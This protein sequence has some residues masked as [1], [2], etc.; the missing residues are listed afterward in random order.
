LTLWFDD[1]IV[2]GGRGGATKGLFLVSENHAMLNAEAERFERRLTEEISGLRVEL[3]EQIA[4]VRAEMYR[5]LQ[6]L[7]LEL[8]DG[9]AAV[10]HEMGIMRAD[11]LKWSFLF[12]VG[13]VATIAALLSYMLRTVNR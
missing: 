11:M 9:L 13:Q 7:R 12:W 8:H 4:G 5:E 6:A 3:H 1:G 2:V 10:R